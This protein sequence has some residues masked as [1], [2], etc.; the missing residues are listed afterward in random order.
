MKSGRNGKASTQ[1]HLQRVQ[2]RKT[3]KSKGTRMSSEKDV[4]RRLFT[5][6]INI[7]MCLIFGRMKA[8][9][10]ELGEVARGLLGFMEKIMLK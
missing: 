1:T 7:K 3:K 5:A 2:K 9:L 4:L 6:I 8:A 10:L